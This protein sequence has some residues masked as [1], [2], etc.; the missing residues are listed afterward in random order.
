M[1]R[2]NLRVTLLAVLILLLTFSF[3]A[4][5]DNEEQES[6]IQSIVITT[7]PKT[8]YYLGDRFSVEDAIITV[9]Y[10]NGKTETV[11]LTLNMI[12][13][14]NANQ[15]G[16]QTLT[17]FYKNKTT[18]LTVTVSSAPVYSIRL[19]ETDKTS[20]K[21]S[22]IIGEE[23][24]VTGMQILVT[25]SNLY[26]DVIDVTEDM[27]SSFSTDN[28]GNTSMSISYGGKFCTAS[29]N[30]V[31]KSPDHVEIS[32]SKEFRIAYVVGDAFE[33]TG[34]SF[35]VHYNDNTSEYL[36]WQTLFDAGKLSFV[37][38]GE[39]AN[40]F[41]S[42]AAERNVYLFYSDDP[43][44]TADPTNPDYNGRARRVGV[45]VT[46]FKPQ[47]L[48]V[49]SDV[50]DQV[51][52]SASYDF[53][54]GQLYVVYN[55]KQTGYTARVSDATVSA[56]KAYADGD[57]R[58]VYSN[59]FIVRDG[60]YV[61]ATL[62][63]S[64]TENYYISLEQAYSAQFDARKKN[65][66]VRSKGS[67]GKERFDL[68][69]GEYDGGTVYY[70]PS[71]ARVYDFTDDKHVLVELND[72][73]LKVVGEYNVVLHVDNLFLEYEVKVVAPSPV[74]L[75]IY[76]SADD[77][78]KDPQT[79]AYYVYQDAVLDVTKWDYKILQ[80]NGRYSIITTSENNSANVSSTESY[81]AKVTN[82]MFNA[83]SAFLTN[84]VIGT[85]N[86]EFSFTTALGVTLA[87][88]V[89]I[90]FR[91]R[92]IQ[93]VVMTV[94]TKTVYS[95]GDNILLEGGSLTARY[96]D[97]KEGE[98]VR[99]SQDMLYCPLASGASDVNYIVLD[100]DGNQTGLIPLTS[101]SSDSFTLSNGNN[102]VYVYYLDSYY[103]TGYV[104]KYDIIVIPKA[105]S[106]TLLESTELKNDYILG[107][108]FT[109]ENWE[110]EITYSQGF[111]SVETE[112]TDERWTIEGTDFS[113]VGT[114]TVT[115]YYGDKA[116]GV[117]LDFVCTVH[118]NVREIRTDKTFIGYTTEGLDFDFS[119]IAFTAI[120]ENGAT[121]SIPLSA[122][123][124]SKRKAATFV[125]APSAYVAA[126]FVAEN[127][128]AN[129][130][131]DLYELSGNIYVRATGAYDGE[132]TYYCGSD[133][134][135]NITFDYNGVTT[136]VT[137][138]VLSRRLTGNV[139]ITAMPAVEYTLLTTLTA[140]DL[141]DF[142]L[143]VSFNNNTTAV[144]KH[145]D[146]GSTVTFSSSTTDGL[147]SFVLNS[148]TYYFSFNGTN[149][150]IYTLSDL[151][152]DK[153][154]TMDE[155]IEKVLSI[156]VWE[157]GDEENKYSDDPFSV[158]CFNKK[159]QSIHVEVGNYSGGVMTPYSDTF[160]YINQGLNLYT[161]SGGVYSFEE[162]N[163][164]KRFVL[165]GDD[166]E[167]YSQHVYVV[168]V[169]E[170][171]EVVY[172]TL[173]EV[174]TSAGFSVSGFKPM[175]AGSQTVTVNY[176]LKQCSFTAYVRPNVVSS[177]S[178]KDGKTASANEVTS[179][180]V[181][182]N[183]AIDRTK[184]YVYASFNDAD[185]DSLDSSF[186][187]FID[188]S[189]AEC[190]YNPAESLTFV[191][192]NS[193]D[194]YYLV[195]TVTVTY[196]GCSKDL[197]L[198]IYKKS[199]SQISMQVMP[200][201]IY[202]EWWE[203]APST[204]PE[205]ALSYTNGN[206]E[207]G[208]VL[209][210]YNN[211]TS[212]VVPLTDARLRI[213]SNQFNTKLALN[214]GAEVSQTIFISFTD[215]N[216][217]SKQTEYNIIVCDRK[218]PTVQYDSS[219]ELSFDNVFYCQY[220]TGSA[221]RPKFLCYY[222]SDF[223]ATGNVE[224]SEKNPD[225]PDL[226]GYTVWYEY[227]NQ[228]T[229]E[230]ETISYWP[231]SVGRYTMVVSYS[232]DYANNAFEDRTIKIEITK[233]QIGI[234]M[235]DIALSYGDR[236]VGTSTDVE[237]LRV[238]GI[239]WS[240][241][242]VLN[243]VLTGDAY[244]GTDT[245]DRVVSVGFEL[246]KD[247]QLVNRVNPL[248]S[249]Y[250]G[251]SYGML[252]MNLDVGEYTIKPVIE[253]LQN[254][255]EVPQG[256]G[257]K[258]AKLTINP[259][260]V[261]IEAIEDRKVY[262]E[263]DP[264]FRYHVYAHT[265][266]KEY[267]G[268]NYFTAIP[269]AD[270]P[271]DANGNRIISNLYVYDSVKQLYLHATAYDV[272]ETYYLLTSKLEYVYYNPVADTTEVSAGGGAVK[273]G[274]YVRVSENEYVIATVY[275]ENE[276]YYTLDP[277]YYYV[278]VEPADIPVV[279]GEKDVTG[280]Y[281]KSAGSYIAATVYDSAETYYQLTVY[282]DKSVGAYRLARRSSDNNNV[283]ETHNILA[284][285]T[286]GSFDNYSIAVY[287]G[288]DL[289]IL[290]APLTITAID[291][292][293][294]YGTRDMNFV[295]GI[296]SDSNLCYNDRFS[297]VFGNY[298]SDRAVYYYN[299]VTK[300]VEEEWPENVGT[301]DE[302]AVL[303]RNISLSGFQT[304]VY[305]GSTYVAV[306][307]NL[308]SGSYSCNLEEIFTDAISNYTVTTAPFEMVIRPIEVQLNVASVIV[309]E[310]S[311]ILDNFGKRFIDYF[312]FA[313]S[314]YV[315]SSN[316]FGERLAPGDYIFDLTDRTLIESTF[317]SRMKKL[318]IG[319]KYT[320]N[321]NDI[322]YLLSSAYL[323]GFVFEKERGTDVGVY[324]VMVGANTSDNFSSFS[325]VSQNPRNNN[326]SYFAYY[327]SALAKNCE[328]V[329]TIV[330]NSTTFTYNSENYAE[331]AYVIILPCLVSL[332]Y[333][334][335]DEEGQ[336]YKEVYDHADNE[337]WTLTTQYSVS[338]KFNPQSYDNKDRYIDLTGTSAVSY[339][340]RLA[341]NKPIDYLVADSYKATISYSY[342]ADV[343]SS[344]RFSTDYIYLGSSAMI[345]DDQLACI[346]AYALFGILPSSQL[347]FSQEFD[348][349][350]LQKPLGVSITNK[351]AGYTGAEQTLVVCVDGSLSST[352]ELN[353]TFDVEVQYNDKS[354]ISTKNETTFYSFGYYSV[355]ASPVKS[356]LSSYY[357]YS[358]SVGFYPTNDTE[359]D[360]SGAKVYYVYHDGSDPS[361]TSY[362]LVNAGDYTITLS[363]IGNDNYVLV[364]DDSVFV[365]FRINPSE[366]PVLLYNNGKMPEI[367]ND[368][369]SFSGQYKAEAYS[370]ID[371]DWN[372]TYFS[373]SELFD[374][375]T[376]SLSGIN[377][378]SSVYHNTNVGQ[379]SIGGSSYY[380]KLYFHDIASPIVSVDASSIRINTSDPKRNRVLVADTENV[381]NDYCLYFIKDKAMYKVFFDTATS[382]Y[383]YK[384][385][386]N[387]VFDSGTPNFAG[388]KG[389]YSLL[390]DASLSLTG[391]TGGGVPQKIGTL[392]KNGAEIDVYIG[393][394][395]TDTVVPT[396]MTLKNENG[397][398]L[399]MDTPSN[400]YDYYFYYVEGGQMRR[401][402][403]EA[404]SDT[405]YYGDEATEEQ[406][407]GTFVRNDVSFTVY[408]A[409]TSNYL[410][411]TTS[412]VI[413]NGFTDLALAQT[414]DGG[415]SNDYYLYFK[416][417]SQVE[418]I[419]Y[420]EGVGYYY[421][422][423]GYVTYKTSTC[424]IVDRY[425]DD[426][427]VLHVPQS[428]KAAPNTLTIFAESEP[429]SGKYPV[430]VKRDPVTD[431]VL[432]YDIV[433]KDNSEFVNY[434]VVFV[435]KEDGIYKQCDDA[436]MYHFYLEPVR[437][438]LS[439]L[440][441]VNSKVY[442]GTA[443]AIRS[444]TQLG[445]DDVLGKDQKKIQD[446]KTSLNNL[447]RFS[448]ERIDQ[449]GST[450]IT[451]DGN[452][453]YLVDSSDNIS[454]GVFKVKARFQNSQS[455]K[456]KI[457]FADNYEIVFE[458]R[459]AYK[460]DQYLYPG[461]TNL[462]RYGIYTISRANVTL[463]FTVSKAQ[464]EYDGYGLQQHGKNYT[465]G[466]TELQALLPSQGGSY[467]GATIVERDY[468][469]I[470]F[471]LSL[472]RYG[473]K[474][475]GEEGAVIYDVTSY[476]ATS[477]TKNSVQ[478]NY[479]CGYYWFT[480]QGVF[481]D[482]NGVLR[483][484]ESRDN[485][486]SAHNK[487]Y[488]ESFRDVYNSSRW[489]NWNY[490]Y[491]VG[492]EDEVL[493]GEGSD[494][495]YRIVERVIYLAI[496]GQLP[497]NSTST[498]YIYKKTYDGTTLS[499]SD[500]E[501]WLKGRTTPY[502]Y[503]AEQQKFIPIA[504]SYFAAQFNFPETPL[505]AENGSQNLTNYG[506]S[507]LNFSSQY[508][509]A[510]KFTE[511]G[512][513]RYNVTVQ[514]YQIGIEIAQL[515]VEVMLTYTN[516]DMDNKQA[517]TYG[518]TVKENTVNFTM[519]ISEEEL[520]KFNQAIDDGNTY[521]ASQV[522]EKLGNLGN[523]TFYLYDQ[524][525]GTN[526]YSLRLQGRSTSIYHYDAANNYYYE[527][528]DGNY[529]DGVI[530][531]SRTRV[532]V[533]QDAVLDKTVYYK[534]YDQYEKTNDT[535]FVANKKY[536]QAT[537]G[538]VSP[539][540]G[541][542]ENTYYE[543]SGNL[544]I[545]TSD[546]VFVANK[547]YYTLE[548][549][550]AYEVGNAV[551]MT[552]YEYH[553]FYLENDDPYF[554]PNETYYT[555]SAVS[556]ATPGVEAGANVPV[557][558]YY[559]YHSDTKR[560]YFTDDTKFDRDKVDTGKYFLIVKADV[561]TG[562]NAILRYYVY[563]NA[564]GG[565][566]IETTDTIAQEGVAYYLFTKTAYSKEQS[567]TD[568]YYYFDGT[569]GKFM[570]AQ[571][572]LD[573]KNHYIVYVDERY[574]PKKGDESRIY[575]TSYYT[576]YEAIEQ[577]TTYVEGDH[578][579]KLIQLKS[580]ADA[581]T[582]YKLVTLLPGRDYQYN[583]AIVGTVYEN[584]QNS[585]SYSISSGTY[586]AGKNYFALVPVSADTSMGTDVTSFYVT[587]SGYSRADDPTY[588]AS[589]EVYYK[590]VALN[591]GA[592]Y[593]VHS[594]IPANTY[595]EKVEGE[596]RYVYTDDLY[597]TSGTSYFVFTSAKGYSSSEF[598]GLF[599]YNNGRYL[600]RVELISG[601][602]YLIGDF[603]SSRNVYYAYEDRFIKETA[604]KFRKNVVYYEFQA[605]N[606]FIRNADVL[607]TDS[608]YYIVSSSAYSVEEMIPGVDY[609][610]NDTIS[611]NVVQ[612]DA[613][614]LTQDAVYENG[615]LYFSYQN[616]G[617]V[618]KGDTDVYMVSAEG[619]FKAASVSGTGIIP[620][621]VYVLDAG[622]Y[623]LA[624]GGT[625][626]VGK[627]YRTFTPMSGYIPSSE[628]G[629]YYVGGERYFSAVML[630]KNTD[631]TVDDAIIGSVYTMKYG[632]L[633]QCES[634]S[635]YVNG[636]EYYRLINKV[637]ND[638]GYVKY[639][640]LGSMYI[641]GNSYY[642]P[643]VLVKDED[644][645]VDN[646]IS[647]SDGSLYRLS[648]SRYITP[649]ESKYLDSVTYCRMYNEG[650]VRYGTTDFAVS[651]DEY[652]S[653]NRLYPTVGQ[654]ISG[655][656]YRK[657]GDVTVLGEQYDVYE[658]ATG[659]YENGQEYYERISGGLIKPADSDKFYMDVSSY[660]TFEAKTA[661]ID[662]VVGET[663]LDTYYVRTMDGRYR[664]TTDAV[665]KASQTY[666]KAKSIGTYLP[667]H[668]SLNGY[669]IQDTVFY[670]ITALRPGV[671]YTVGTTVSAGTYV[672]SDTYYGTV[673]G[674]GQKYRANTTYL[675]LQATVGYINAGRANYTY[676]ELIGDTEYVAVEANDYQV[677]N[678][679]PASKY[680][681]ALSDGRLFPVGGDGSKF[682]SD[683]TYFII[684]TGGFIFADNKDDIYRVQS[685]YYSFVPVEVTPGDPVS[686]YYR[687]SA[688]GRMVSC[689]GAAAAGTVYY[690]V[691][692][693]G[694]VRSGN[695]GS[696]YIDGTGYYSVK[697]TTP[698]ISAYVYYGN[699]SFIEATEVD[700]THKYYAFFDNDGYVRR[701]KIYQYYVEADVFRT[702]SVMYDYYKYGEK[703]P[704]AVETKTTE[705]YGDI[706]PGRVYESV[707][708][709]FIVTEDDYFL[710]GKQYYVFV[711]K[712]YDMYSTSESVPYNVADL[713]VYR[714]GYAQVEE[715][716]AKLVKAVSGV[717][718]RPGNQV[719]GTFFTLD[720]EK[721]APVVVSA[722]GGASF[723]S[724]TTYY[725]LTDYYGIEKQSVYYRWS[726]SDSTY[727]LFTEERF[728]DDDYYTFD[729]AENVSGQIN[730]SFY[731][732]KEGSSF[733]S[734]TE[735]VFDSAK[736]YYRLTNA[737]VPSGGFVVAG[738]YEYVEGSKIFV[739]T[740][741][742]TQ[743]DG[744]SYY[745]F[746]KD[747]SVNVSDPVRYYEKTA[748]GYVLTSDAKSDLSKKYY[749]FK[750]SSEKVKTSEYNEIAIPVGDVLQEGIY[751]KVGNNYVAAVGEA[752]SGTTYYERTLYSTSYF[753]GVADFAS[754]KAG[755]YYTAGKDARTGGNFK[756]KFVSTAFSVEK[757][758]VHITGVERTYYDDTAV[759]R[760][761]IVSEDTE[762]SASVQ[763]L[764]YGENGIASSLADKSAK[765][766]NAGSYFTFE[767]AS[768]TNNYYMTIPESL[769]RN[770]NQGDNNYYIVCDEISSSGGFLSLPLYIRRAPVVVDINLSAPIQYGLSPTKDNLIS[771]ANLSFGSEYPKTGLSDQVNLFNFIKGDEVIKYEELIDIVSTT[772]YSEEGKIV[773]LSLEYELVEKE[774]SALKDKMDLRSTNYD[775][776]FGKL[777][778][779]ISKR[780]IPIKVVVRNTFYDP[781]HSS[782][783][784]RG[785]PFTI[786][787][788]D[789]DSLFYE[790]GVTSDILAYALEIDD[791]VSGDTTYMRSDLA[792]QMSEI[793][794]SME[795]VGGKIR[796]TKNGKI[797]DTIQDF[798]KL[799]T[800]YTIVDEDGS[801]DVM[802]G[803]NYVCLEDSNWYESK[804]YVLVSAK[805]PIIIY[806]EIESIGEYSDGK[807][808]IDMVA[809]SEAVLNSSTTVNA[810]GVIEN[811]S[812]II[813]LNM[814]GMKNTVY[815]YSTQ[816][817]DSMTFGSAY[818]NYYDG[819]GY[820]RV[821]KLYYVSGGMESGGTVTLRV[822]DIITVRAEVSEAF[823]D[824]G[825]R[826]TVK[827]LCFRLRI[828]DK[829]NLSSENSVT[830]ISMSDISAPSSDNT[831]LY[832]STGSI[833]KN[834]GAVASDSSG[835]YL[836]YNDNGTV[837][838]ENFDTV[839]LRVKLIPLSGATEYK[840]E[841]LVYENSVGKLVFGSIAGTRRYSYVRYYSKEGF[842]F[843]SP[844]AASQSGV[845]YYKT[846]ALT[847]EEVNT[848]IENGSTAKYYRM[849][850]DMLYEA[851]GPYV[852]TITYY[853][854]Q[855]T[856]FDGDIVLWT[857]FCEEEI[858]LTETV[859]SEGKTSERSLLPDLFD[860]SSH[861]LVFSIDRIGYLT[862]MVKASQSSDVE[863]NKND[864]YFTTN[865]GDAFSDQKAYF[866]YVNAGLTEG[867]LLYDLTE[868]NALYYVYDSVAGIYRK[869][870]T[871]YAQS[872]ETYYSIVHDETVN[873]S[874]NLSSYLV[875]QTFATSTSTYLFTHSRT[876][877]EALRNFYLYLAVDDE[878][879]YSSTVSG[880]VFCSDIDQVSVTSNKL[881]VNYCDC[882][883]FA[884][885]FK[886]SG[887]VTGISSHASAKMSEETLDSFEQ[888]AVAFNALL[889]NYRAEF[890]GETKNIKIEGTADAYE[891]Y[892]NLF[893]KA[894]NLFD[895]SN[896]AIAQRAV[897]ELDGSVVF[898][899]NKPFRL[900]S[901]TLSQTYSSLLTAAAR[902]FGF[903][904]NSSF[905]ETVESVASAL[906]KRT[907]KMYFDGAIITPDGFVFPYMFKN[908][909]VND[910][911]LVAFLFVDNN[912][913]ISVWFNSASG[914]MTIANNNNVLSLTN[915]AQLE[916]YG[917]C[918]LFET[919]RE[920]KNNVVMNYIAGLYSYEY[921][922]CYDR[923]C[924][925]YS[926]VDLTKIKVDYCDCDVL[927]TVE[928]KGS[929][930]K[931][932]DLMQHSSASMSNSN[933]SNF[934]S[935]ASL[936]ETFMADYTMTDELDTWTNS[937]VPS[938]YTSLF[939][940]IKD[941]YKGAYL[942]VTKDLS[943]TASTGAIV[944]INNQYIMTFGTSAA[945][946]DILT[947]IA[948]LFGY[949]DKAAFVANA[950][951]LA[952]KFMENAARANYASTSGRLRY[953]GAVFTGSGSFIMP[954]AFKN[955]SSD[956]A[957]LALIILDRNDR[958]SVWISSSTVATRVSNYSGSSQ[959]T[960]DVY[961]RC[962][963]FDAP[964]Y[965]MDSTGVVSGVVN[966]VQE[967]VYFFATKEGASLKGRT[968]LSYNNVQLNVSDFMTSKRK[969]FVTMVDGRSFIRSIMI[970]PAQFSDKMQ[971]VILTKES[972]TTFAEM[973]DA[974]SRSIVYYAPYGSDD[975]NV[976]FKESSLMPTTRIN[977]SKPQLFD[978]NP[979]SDLSVDNP[980]YGLYTIKVPITFNYS[981][982]GQVVEKSVEW[983]Y[984]IIVTDTAT[985]D[986]MSFAQY[987]LSNTSGL[988]E[989]VNDDES[990]IPSGSIAETFVG[991]NGS[992]NYYYNEDPLDHSS[993][994][995][996][997]V[998][999][1000][1001]DFTTNDADAWIYLA[1002]SDRELTDLKNNIISNNN[1003]WSW[1004][1005]SGLAI[1006]ITPTATYL[1007]SSFSAPNYV[1008]AT[1009]VYVADRLYYKINEKTGKYELFTGYRENDNV[1010]DGV[1011][1012]IE[1013]S[1014]T[1015][1016][1017]SANGTPYDDS[1018]DYYRRTVE[1019][1020]WT[1021]LTFNAGDAISGT[1022]VY[1023]K[1024]PSGEPEMAS[1025]VYELGVKYYNVDF[1026]DVFT[1027]IDNVDD[1028]PLAGNIINGSDIYTPGREAK[1029]D[1030]NTVYNSRRYEDSEA[1031]NWERGRNILRTDYIRNGEDAIISVSLYQY[1032]YDTERGMYIT[1033]LVWQEFFKSGLYSV[1034]T[1035][1036]GT[1037]MSV[1038][1039]GKSVVQN[1040]IDNMK[1041]V[1042][1043]G[1044]KNTD[1045]TIY[1046]HTMSTSDI[1047][1048]FDLARTS[1049][1050]TYG[1051]RY[1052]TKREPEPIVSEKAGDYRVDHE[1053]EY[1054]DGHSTFTT[1055]MDMASNS[1056]SLYMVGGGEYAYLSDEYGIPHAYTG[1057]GVSMTFT[1058]NKKEY[1059]IP[1060]STVNGQRF[1061][1062]YFANSTPM[1063]GPFSSGSG[1064]RQRGLAIVSM[1065][1066]F[1067]ESTGTVSTSY[1068]LEFY[1069]SDK[1070]YARQLLQYG[1071]YNGNDFVYYDL[1072]DGNEHTITVTI[1073]RWCESIDELTEEE[1074][1075]SLSWPGD[1076]FSK[1077]FEIAQDLTESGMG[1078]FHVV[1079]VSI[1080]DMVT[1081]CV[1082][1083]HENDLSTIELVDNQMAADQEAN[1084]P[1085]TYERY[1086]LEGIYYTGIRTKADITIKDFSTFDTKE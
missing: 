471:N 252:L 511:I 367:T 525:S 746:V 960:V 98:V 659:S 617:Y 326:V 1033:D 450:Y 682:K 140:W 692:N 135:T 368:T 845:T 122:L 806:P 440:Y 678:T 1083:P 656:V 1062:W 162:N 588:L 929:N 420:M 54:Q 800:K 475:P 545:L 871:L 995:S 779:V 867:A 297:D 263:D 13:D 1002:L 447:L 666:Y 91:H 600:N 536:Y 1071:Y 530:Y 294:P 963:L 497:A 494:G 1072:A 839:S 732:V 84:H 702:D 860:G 313:E 338:E 176:L 71:N 1054:I 695:F 1032:Y 624:T 983:V 599:S 240:M 694:Y 1068:A 356:M 938:A 968:G 736:T 246:Y 278:V 242:G 843:K 123:D 382:N 1050:A 559:E 182:E 17:I 710:K 214:S 512:E 51:L 444:T 574:D 112:F 464:K 881:N 129:V 1008:L 457:D 752:Q 239:E 764:L 191:E 276:T 417:G 773:S 153:T 976:A 323:T 1014:N 341:S 586:V 975:N 322:D 269:A 893:N 914:A 124:V 121:E 717:D 957:L 175:N 760:E 709:K 602:D 280:L 1:K 298:F 99:F 316:V 954:F 934:D 108:E 39:D 398:T 188:F 679:I 410:L 847:G 383:Y 10:E 775:V 748:D 477:F 548:K 181:I 731:F 48:A 1046:E 801:D 822:G 9:Y 210:R 791:F 206:G 891:D 690:E 157:E 922:F 335:V 138:M 596:N 222:Y 964:V 1025:G 381:Q 50:A 402:F 151:K 392:R 437:L 159:V 412:S 556:V 526:S 936:F 235:E 430:N 665:F 439:N 939:N 190:T 869:P 610:V 669:Y 562:K 900:S 11:P 529:V 1027:L 148:K 597:F 428:L 673:T 74:A 469:S 281:Y 693:A 563:D 395:I 552:L 293:R 8:E 788:S 282:V 424:I 510:N 177:I 850:G 324:R 143:Q 515:E 486:T 283:N 551:S 73:T 925:D 496:D 139:V 88:T 492:K 965:D 95:V 445:I 790:P 630:V 550:T 47:K 949:S 769:I 851:E 209:V 903:A 361:T 519:S 253:V 553:Q 290:P 676:R 260:E 982:N 766:S 125:S 988:M 1005:A 657:T 892:A 594:L 518:K 305:K 865:G 508:Q 533:Q 169:Y 223:Y 481:F 570:R 637:N 726:E 798:L 879:A 21:S 781:D 901:G 38:D 302:W 101:C 647:N 456:G 930:L 979:S 819:Q 697:E 16:E 43:N 473:Y 780:Q 727:V 309:Y 567:V 810:S 1006:K 977:I 411:T 959:E 378:N 835:D 37:I 803:V 564:V 874:T 514:N 698:S 685:S 973:L 609:N 312:N 1078:G 813:R 70:I 1000:D 215:D 329:N 715:S 741:D 275:D 462:Y 902:L 861:T 638:F 422:E 541:V 981:R 1086:F 314:D 859:T 393:Y 352:D 747:S 928:S 868:Y 577:A 79:G 712:T 838:E 1038:I 489:L 400:S 109:M 942:S 310:Q 85:Y 642:H 972:A 142:T 172:K 705:Y 485:L 380:V 703:I 363:S 1042:G 688:D 102:S 969:A 358:D 136:T 406:A 386:G 446:E 575:N 49:F 1081:Y 878:V 634:G 236:F 856:P 1039:V 107:Q 164:N 317:A 156:R 815:D 920:S 267:L 170:G 7:M 622:R 244:V 858:Q 667:A 854:L 846:T 585:D 349:T 229:Q 478:T 640:D 931:T 487:E 1003:D 1070:E 396:G 391:V 66:Y 544:L 384:P 613:F 689:N 691:T 944:G 285:S 468:D 261:E 809:D 848:E 774:L 842:F 1048:D 268:G 625:Y 340:I 601:V 197:D 421:K 970:Y 729:V 754:L 45:T 331:G 300:A 573:D 572:S 1029:D 131:L 105:V 1080:D 680:Y 232:G 65:L 81:T 620:E 582:Y 831:K 635:N 145:S 401:I 360:T 376:I 546:D 590:L 945:Y 738:L 528:V 716:F 543:K 655:T 616:D 34:G 832:N 531:Y 227:L 405:Y 116:D 728:G 852:V 271:T 513:E 674:S 22:Y 1053:G 163:D 409:F 749:Y 304:V 226:P 618:Q 1076:G 668:A 279:L 132:K 696:Y 885:V 287:T 935:V 876:T 649:T 770:Y 987:R 452:E 1058:L 97:G 926:S 463:Q 56:R 882:N 663:V 722:S 743:Q 996:S 178:F 403:Y 27:V 686:G 836:L 490:I 653:F 1055:D 346:L 660:R 67:D 700:P 480:Y 505:R 467:Q 325:V 1004:R 18:F 652:Y 500:A 961:G 443:A 127:D 221:K 952:E 495:V 675:K 579:Y 491:T 193:D 872:G 348:Y 273:P 953:D 89:P 198:T 735:D 110:V 592:D 432:G 886:D 896:S 476:G 262:G 506:E 797:Y 1017:E 631:Y 483:Q 1021:E 75:E 427:N 41:T 994:N 171:D 724:T 208:T 359:V 864:R 915:A 76:P 454:A 804:N 319:A 744:K 720:K 992:F 535:H 1075:A 933:I 234:V 315:V 1034:S 745:K 825:T 72:F 189:D 303:Y 431:E 173:E 503:D 1009:G 792:G 646:A 1073:G 25:Y 408:I 1056:L 414:V 706:V 757:Q 247:N 111:P 990:M 33:L 603:I 1049:F 636:T 299:T 61:P 266:A 291:A 249:D 344:S 115:L 213:N 767:S 828:V 167:K 849:K 419:Y 718:Y 911:V 857:D 701:D 782:Y 956:E 216:N 459:S 1085:E 789:K 910:T 342:F 633:V 498:Q 888:F 187:T 740:K 134:L 808:Y 595:Y 211:G 591:E 1066:L 784:F 30:V 629:D 250:Y 958:L 827:S 339:G 927:R 192:K 523:I 259:K 687:E 155:Y 397:V 60:G 466:Y 826:P 904:D 224:L 755:T 753:T 28:E 578:Y 627:Q 771:D 301:Y 113:T 521:T 980:G 1031:I 243:G 966:A 962:M 684:A 776:T 714:K 841:T 184:I 626:A 332:K 817:F 375:C 661:G 147:Y 207:M 818:P 1047:A 1022:N 608:R 765:A 725:R 941:L 42:S 785:N 875:G 231:V 561:D 418:K 833:T 537:P 90:E 154:A 388:L 1067:D 29:Y 1019:Y 345:R 365:S 507:K 863:I 890:T 482:S 751:V 650:Y 816:Y 26:T 434:S 763:T 248:I 369:Y 907:N 671:D 549:Y 57:W 186:S 948:N 366:I 534:Y 78:N 823:S 307:I 217:V 377:N 436:H 333:Y 883:V 967:D 180:S 1084:N 183:M 40:V 644:Y 12:S 203:N 200:L 921:S 195:K 106:I 787:Y 772:D 909:K 119:G 374:A 394:H 1015:N 69:T 919:S 758:I 734:P 799:E 978:Y 502:Y 230:I 786:L 733:V 68:A 423:A 362:K 918:S 837:Y 908:E 373:N 840:F 999:F 504:D 264:L 94:P 458:A 913:T 59:Y 429:G 542:K 1061:M 3:F 895:N 120:R 877:Y 641:D 93:S 619:F 194:V 866:T 174:Q 870:S 1024:T 453:Y 117:K 683:V 52:D 470:F 1012:Y 884:E 416:N 1074:L 165:H 894:K 289:I 479:N 950:T 606:G 1041:Y 385:A 1065:E 44:Y 448:F 527:A 889:D 1064:I 672:V 277:F 761:F 844:H 270:V 719:T 308:A 1026:I 96:I 932:E 1045:V 899:I 699:G 118:N 762:V 997:T 24:D 19:Y 654:P 1016:Y 681:I 568:H 218:T 20:Y 158:Y 834:F 413:K 103:D 1036:E 522:L 455:N 474:L 295:Y 488:D 166:K 802:A 604:E 225:I 328:E 92:T 807:S 399:K 778:Y 540:N 451:I 1063:F 615:K 897:Y 905:I 821:L 993:I 426:E 146:S 795:N 811:L 565:R 532:S 2:K 87:C 441:Q 336:R 389:G 862:D 83:S 509:D 265:T 984:N 924:S 461:T 379:V 168:I 1010:E 524:E 372:R 1082:C 628:I 651:A 77:V 343:A 742:I 708:D 15:L 100:I 991:G 547:E 639:S 645:T 311:Q 737:L 55:S 64:E 1051:F 587:G 829:F 759:G 104:V 1007:Y 1057:N 415:D 906:V 199:I 658:L 880:S 499:G 355:V 219:T 643:I 371:A 912:G 664:V 873:G 62:D 584:V 998:I 257:D 32:L 985:P 58:S 228:G 1023:I 1035:D 465:G 288:A 1013:K 205:P 898:G 318:I 86:Y 407:V 334:R 272:G 539:G 648:G 820:E 137:A 986:R 351:D 364:T 566:W 677:G 711:E 472:N 80:N 292:S 783:S 286:E 160:V 814:N 1001:L 179:T 306:P 793:I 1037:N 707:E 569:T 493:V 204:D 853:R 6:P 598:S 220:G 632:R 721:G 130:R 255:Y 917:R 201:Q 1043:W 357:N 943:Y 611:G 212:E 555:V 152:A 581:G 812:Y 36:D 777:T 128:W 435:Y 607:D 517:V 1069:K 830:T 621:N 274:Y 150:G 593:T 554:I 114:H 354:Y 730:K 484:Y 196:D 251:A 245:Q 623:S 576:E 460:D 1040:T 284:G 614:K 558:T 126:G 1011:Y 855:T 433:F 1052:S 580:S 501:E 923:N 989:K 442:D 670:S 237:A 612:A 1079:R 238:L 256:I 353:F 144:I 538:S 583:S 347:V 796:N 1020:E 723:D 1077:A 53:S 330:S 321:G 937:T 662:Y 589:D 337:I 23:L 149:S 1018:K 704:Y 824:F 141:R 916:V 46:A 404:G 14:F 1044:L 350:V 750:Q 571:T 390:T 5:N 805:T 161:V 605:A 713:Y 1028:I 1059:D 258:C 756:I 370:P 887:E 946:D 425:Y 202:P 520:E 940:K 35:F 387:L 971:T 327:Y 560:F 254:N 951:T 739:I 955:R 4:C 449:E 320:S 133:N 1030:A 768:E 233:K 1060:G 438:T 557:K 516:V 31:K 241:S 82:D 296:A 63:Y 185:G 974:V 794:S 947:K